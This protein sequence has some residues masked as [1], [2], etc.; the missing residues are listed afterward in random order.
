MN[1]KEESLAN[2]ILQINTIFNKLKIQKLDQMGM[3]L[4]C[5]YCGRK[6]FH[7]Y[8]YRCLLCVSYQLCARC[9][10]K[11]CTSE[12]H[13][14]YHPVVRCDHKDDEDFLGVKIEQDE[15]NMN[16]FESTFASEKHSNVSCDACEMDTIH[17]LRFKCEICFDYDLCKRC[18]SSNKISKS[19]ANNH[20]MVVIPK[21]R[22]FEIDKNKVE[23]IGDPIGCGAFG[24]VYKAKLVESGKFVACK[25]IKV[26]AL[27]RMLGFKPEELIKSF[28]RE[29]SI[30][31]QVKVCVYVF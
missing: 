16:W 8:L 17:G 21:T 5:T 24:S 31:N 19:H 1:Q 22:S 10:E 7:G 28:F 11:R 14:S 27:R 2:K 6:G 20:P 18:F 29:L 25:I 4:E 3:N 30:Y 26:D 13:E 23:L 9:F 12:S 15:Y